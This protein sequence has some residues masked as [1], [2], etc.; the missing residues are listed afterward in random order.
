ME[1]DTGG[2][3]ISRIYRSVVYQ[4]AKEQISTTPFG[5][6]LNVY[7][8]GYEWVNHSMNPLDLHSVPNQQ[9][10]I[11]VGGP[12]C[13]R[14]Y[15]LSIFNISAMSFGSLSSNA[16]ESLNWGAKVG[17]FAHNTG[18]GGLSDYHLKHGGDIIWQIGTGYFGC[19]NDDG[20][21]NSDLFKKKATLENVKMM[22]GDCVGRD[23][24]QWRLPGR[25]RTTPRSERSK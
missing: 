12:D 11:T 7:E 20:T 14:P 5:T 8:P 21:F 4:R 18:E 24:T 22:L 25:G 2:T 19:R 3:P 6:Q 15:S 13:K 16:I 1:S 9:M 17:N 10:R 23:G